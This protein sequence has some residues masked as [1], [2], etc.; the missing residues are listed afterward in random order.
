LS[1][2]HLPPVRNA[3]RASGRTRHRLTGAVTSA[4]AASLL[5]ISCGSPASKQRSAKPSPAAG[6][7]YTGPTAVNLRED[8]GPKANT[9][10]TLQHGE[11]LE[12][13]E[14][15]RRFVRVRTSTGVEGWT[16]ANY[17][18]SQ[19]QVSDLDKL[20][21]FAA[22]LPS[23]GAGTAYDALNVHTAPSRQAPSFT[24]IPE[25]GVAEV[26]VHRVAPRN[27]VMPPAAAPA[28]KSKASSKT[29]PPKQAKQGKEPPPPPPPAPA[30]PANWVELSRP[31]ASELPGEE[32]VA[33]ATPQAAPTPTDDWYL[34]RGRDG[35]AGWVLARQISLSIPDEVAQYA[36]GHVITS[37][38]SLGKVGSTDK[39][40]WLW[41]TMSAASQGLDF[42]SFRV[43]VWS[44]KKNRYE[45]AY[46][47]RNVKGRYP[48]ETAQS[49]SG[50]EAAFS[51]VLEDKDGQVYKKTYA[52][53]GYRVRMVSKTP[54]PAPP[55]VPEVR[56]SRSFEEVQ[57]AQKLSWRDTLRDARR[58]WF[59]R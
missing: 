57:V 50:Q 19:Q 31:R 35:K 56:T 28:K 2:D 22:K 29:A 37:Y 43:F 46:I 10:A 13:L 34:V 44:T 54:N 14:T 55:D 49:G 53:S 17:L 42:D 21:E 25:G 7:A 16:D 40:N 11:R 33:A 27:P 30:P 3:A 1:I 39:D 23:Q 58:R 20:A 36:E 41:T 15:R 6:I 8:L 4:L 48:I 18:L 9:V 24:Q 32:P 38:L 52:F 51:V 5:L 45:T 12:V 59:G 47:E 26:L